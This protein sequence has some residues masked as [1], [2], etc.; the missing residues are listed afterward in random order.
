MTAVIPNRQQNLREPIKRS[1][2]RPIEGV[3]SVIAGVAAL[4][5]T[6]RSNTEASLSAWH[7]TM[8]ASGW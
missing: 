4:V 2:P 3:V 6:V 7:A 5:M 8:V 1:A